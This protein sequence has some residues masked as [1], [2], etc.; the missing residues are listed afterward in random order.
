MTHTFKP[1]FPTQTQGAQPY[2]LQQADRM[3]QG[4]ERGAH[5]NVIHSEMLSVEFHVIG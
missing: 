3:G 2:T 4:S 1:L 5:V